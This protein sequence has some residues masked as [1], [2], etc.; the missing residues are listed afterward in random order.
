MTTTIII[1]H[2]VRNFKSCSP[3]H[4]EGAGTTER[5]NIM[6]VI[7]NGSRRSLAT[8]IIPQMPLKRNINTTQK[9]VRDVCHF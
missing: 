7:F 2:L 1:I 3:G 8:Q 5:R 9:E 4:A 6:F